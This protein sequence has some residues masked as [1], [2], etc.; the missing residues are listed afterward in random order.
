MDLII[1][2]MRLLLS[3]FLVI[4]RNIEHGKT[5]VLPVLH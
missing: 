5:L 1:L 4:K 2:E 3:N